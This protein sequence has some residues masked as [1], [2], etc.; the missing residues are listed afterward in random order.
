MVEI[1]HTIEN[2]APFIGGEQTVLFINNQDSFIYN[3]VNYICTISDAKVRIVPNSITCDEIDQC[4]PDKIIIS[5]GPGHPKYD[6]GN[7]IP[8]IQKFGSKIPI[9]GV[10]LGHQAIT[11]A[12]GKDKEEEYV[13]RAKMGP[14][15]GK[16]SKIFHDG[17]GIF[18]D[19]P[20]PCSVVRYHSLVTKAD[21]LPENLKI[22]AMADDGAIM[23]IKHKEFPIYGVQFH[24]ESIMMKPNGIL[25]LANFLKI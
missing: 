10:C 15:H 5:P 20:N 23:G 12:F 18:A 24:P 14:M 6:T 4:N 7:I 2:N 11:E 19:I 8:I 21:L 25:I 22:A 16:M 1:A 13:G 17:E 9:L 3:I